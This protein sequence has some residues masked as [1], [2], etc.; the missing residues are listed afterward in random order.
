MVPMASTAAAVGIVSW[1]AVAE[2]CVHVCLSLGLCLWVLCGV[3]SES[4]LL[5]VGRCWG[6]GGRTAKA[7][8]YRFKSFQS[9]ANSTTVHV[10]G[11]WLRFVLP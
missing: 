9:D 8:V 5:Y 1:L 11:E 2:V 10:Y 7:R 6:W 3:D 4:E